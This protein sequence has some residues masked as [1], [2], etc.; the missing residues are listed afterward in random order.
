VGVYVAAQGNNAGGF[1][2]DRVEQ[3]HGVTCL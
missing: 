3:F 2:G 1:G